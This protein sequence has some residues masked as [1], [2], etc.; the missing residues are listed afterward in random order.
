MKKGFGTAVILGCYYQRQDQ[1]A[2]A[3]ELSVEHGAS[4]GF[5]HEK[6][7]QHFPFHFKGSE[8]DPLVYDKLRQLTGSAPDRDEAASLTLAAWLSEQ[9]MNGG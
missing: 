2:R 8:D 6:R 4:W 3:A 7:N 5:M 1:A 9:E